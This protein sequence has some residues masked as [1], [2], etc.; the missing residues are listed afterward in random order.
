MR[1]PVGELTS[2]SVPSLVQCDLQQCLQREK[3]GES[4]RDHLFSWRY[5]TGDNLEIFQIRCFRS[6]RLEKNICSDSFILF[7]FLLL[8]SW[9]V[10]LHHKLSESF[11]KSEPRSDS[12]GLIFSWTLINIS[13]LSTD[14][15]VGLF[16]NLLAPIGPWKPPPASSPGP[17]GAPVAAVSP[18]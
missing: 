9:C 5:W 4:E 18:S 15:D 1:F 14:P 13:L 3:E 6:K 16:E 11:R 10:L 7:Y 8:V 2:D 17:P 12:Y